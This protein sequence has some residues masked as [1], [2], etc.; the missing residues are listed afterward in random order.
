M[1]GPYNKELIEAAAAM[2]A[3]ALPE[4]S[5]KDDPARY[6]DAFPRRREGGDPEQA[7]LLRNR[8]FSCLHE[9]EIIPDQGGNLRARQDLSYPPKDLI[10]GGQVVTAPFERWAAYPDRPSNWLHHKAL[11]RNRLAAIDR[12]FH[13]GGEPPKWSPSRASK[14]TIAEWL[15]ALVKAGKPSD[16]AEASKAAVQV[17]ALIPDEIRKNADPGEIVLTAAG[18]LRK[19]DPQSPIPNPSSCRRRKH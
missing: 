14:A 11:R 12:L 18:A 17:A 10:Q 3:E 9:R 16:A 13:P 8:L 19:P 6:L 5:T 1:P 2:I 7:D 4:L 15:E